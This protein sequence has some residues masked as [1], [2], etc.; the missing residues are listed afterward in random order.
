[1]KC[2]CFIFHKFPMHPKLIFKSILTKTISIQ[3]NHVF[4]TFRVN[5]LKM[6]QAGFGTYQLKINQSI[7]SNHYCGPPNTIFWFTSCISSSSIGLSFF[8]NKRKKALLSSVHFLLVQIVLSYKN[9]HSINFSFEF[10][11]VRVIIIANFQMC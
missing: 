1:M 6:N 9:L 8:R 7:K 2:F 3:H 10:F 11:P 4:L 5:I